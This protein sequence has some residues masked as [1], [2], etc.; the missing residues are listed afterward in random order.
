MSKAGHNFLNRFIQPRVDFKSRTWF[1]LMLVIFVLSFV[2]LCTKNLL[3]LN[4]NPTD[5]ALASGIQ[6]QGHSL[7]SQ[8]SLPWP[9]GPDFLALDY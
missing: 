1:V 3:L 4:L 2:Y 9:L 6:I 7:Q 8:V 5:W